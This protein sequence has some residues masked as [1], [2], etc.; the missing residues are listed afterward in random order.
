MCLL[1]DDRGYEHLKQFGIRLNDL[2]AIKSAI[3]AKESKLELAESKLKKKNEGE[4]FNFYRILVSVKNTIKRDV[5]VDKTC[6][7]EWVEL[8]AGISEQNK[9]EQQALMKQK[10]RR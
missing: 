1:L 3:S 5:D 8:L 10:N 6:L 9:A 7:A 4:A 2:D